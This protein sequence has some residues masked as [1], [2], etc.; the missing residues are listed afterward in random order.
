MTWVMVIWD[1]MDRKKFK[2]P[3]SINLL[4]KACGSPGTMQ[5]A[6]FAHHPDV[7]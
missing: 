4:E 2:L 3:I 5:G 1:A 6:P 7:A